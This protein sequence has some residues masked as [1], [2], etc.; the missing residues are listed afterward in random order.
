[1][2]GPIVP[3]TLKTHE[4]IDRV[5]K[6][7]RWSVFLSVTLGYTL[8]YVCRLN[9]A[10]IKKPL[11]EQGLFN[12]EQL[13][14]IGSVMFI[15]Y[16]VGKFL[17]GF[18]ADRLNIKNF[19]SLGLFATATV[20]LILGNITYFWFF[21]VLWGLNGWFQSF[22]AAPSVVALSQ[23]F[24][25]RE[26]GT[27]YGIWIISHNLGSGLTAVGTAYFVKWW[28]WQYGFIVPGAVALIGSYFLYRFMF[29]R[30]QT[31]GLPPV[32][33][34]RNDPLQTSQTESVWELQKEVIRKP[35]VWI[36]G[37]SSACMYIAR[38]AFESWG[39]VFMGAQKGYSTVTAGKLVF[40]SQMFGL[41]A[42]MLCGYVTDKFFASRRNVLALI[43][44]ILYAVSLAVFLLTKEKSLFIDC[45]SLAVYGLSL[46]VL[47]TFLGGLMA[48]DICSKRS[49]GAAMGM[50]GLFSYVA[51]AINDYVSGYLINAHKT[52]VNGQPVYDFTPV[53]ILWIS[54]AVLSFIFA[55]MVWKE[56]QK[57]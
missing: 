15:T 40:M 8:F 53:S 45:A 50:I 10:I 42:T 14:L 39:I 20:S 49:A 12:A 55:A 51:T 47:L 43:T 52:M 54:A 19:M 46:G 34:Y 18:F 56:R 36:L 29:D 9:F 24:S 38:Y 2:T 25:T 11:M 57:G 5:Y 31:L 27:Y 16:A 26:M 13:G 23:W 22:G 28:G 7:K 4:E 30:P 41:V 35:A 17:N 37:L 6:P 21:V 48:V 44:G 3:V 1:M 32:Y 33:V